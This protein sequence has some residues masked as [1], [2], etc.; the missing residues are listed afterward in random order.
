MICSQLNIHFSSCCSTPAPASAKLSSKACGSP[1]QGSKREAGAGAGER[2]PQRGP[3]LPPR[4]GGDFTRRSQQNCS[5]LDRVFPRQL[6]HR[7]LR[8]ASSA[9]T[10]AESTLQRAR[11]GAGSPAAA[12]GWALGAEGTGRAG[13]RGGASRERPERSR[14]GPGPAPTA[15][16]SGRVLPG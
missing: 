10:L 12:A 16:C 11:A 3:A 7:G 5:D 8:R 4:R 6:R 14:A 1:F 13:S 15:S 9:Q 2:R